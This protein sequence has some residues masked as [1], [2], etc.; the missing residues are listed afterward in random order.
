MDLLDVAFHRKSR[1]TFSIEAKRIDIEERIIR[2]IHNVY[3]VCYSFTR[4]ILIKMVIGLHIIS[5]FK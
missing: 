2:N 1:G 5:N 3:N 4:T